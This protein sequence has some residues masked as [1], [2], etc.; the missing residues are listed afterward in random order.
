MSSVGLQ[1]K[2]LR[3][4]LAASESRRRMDGGFPSHNKQGKKDLSEL[5]KVGSF[6]KFF[7][8]GFSILLLVLLNFCLQG[9]Y[10]VICL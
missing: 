1:G 10:I 5:G 7:L 4:T 2:E 9:A 6:L 8:F 3:A